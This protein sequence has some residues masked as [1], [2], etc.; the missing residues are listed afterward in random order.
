MIPVSDVIAFSELETPTLDAKTQYSR[1]QPGLFM[2]LQA[3][4]GLVKT[5]RNKYKGYAV[6]ALLR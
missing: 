1:I 6:G 2:D 3:S 5:L 4:S